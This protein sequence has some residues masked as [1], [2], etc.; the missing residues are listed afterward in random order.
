MFQGSQHLPKGKADE[1]IEAAGGS[2]NGSTTRA[3]RGSTFDRT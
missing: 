2:S 3:S 1:L